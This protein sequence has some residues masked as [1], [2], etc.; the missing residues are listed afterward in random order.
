MSWFAASDSIQINGETN[1]KTNAHG[2]EQPAEGVRFVVFFDGLA[3]LSFGFH[4][5]RFAFF[6]KG[7]SAG[8]AAGL[9]HRTAFTDHIFVWMW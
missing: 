2:E 3:Y 9:L 6:K 1:D 4:E 7:R 8:K 5:G